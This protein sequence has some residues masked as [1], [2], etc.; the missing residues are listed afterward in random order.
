[1]IKPKQIPESVA[2]IAEKTWARSGDMKEA[3]AAALQAWPG[4]DQ[5]LGAV[6]LPLPQEN[7][8]AEG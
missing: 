7:T 3:I 5:Y 8:N 2:V 6:V 1:M 4:A